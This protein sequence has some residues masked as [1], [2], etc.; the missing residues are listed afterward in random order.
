MCPRVTPGTKF[1]A[2]F[3]KER[4][5]RQTHA[6]KSGCQLQGSG[7]IVKKINSPFYRNNEENNSY[8]G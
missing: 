8:G 1:I 5:K 6:E 4:K 3:A 2:N 7:S